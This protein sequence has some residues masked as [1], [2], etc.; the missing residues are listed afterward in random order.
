[1][2]SRSPFGADR[3]SAVPALIVSL[4]AILMGSS[5]AAASCR[6][7]PLMKFQLLAEHGVP[8]EVA[9]SSMFPGLPIGAKIF[10]KQLVDGAPAAG[11]VVAFCPHED[12][13]TLYVKRVIGLPGDRVQMTDDQLYINR[14]PVNRVADGTAKS[15]MGDVLTCYK[16]TLAAR[17][18]RACTAAEPNIYADTPESLVPPGRVFV[19]GDNRDNS[20][21]SRDPDLGLV[22]IED[23]VGVSVP[24]V[25]NLIGTPAAK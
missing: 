11:D 17:T 14:K 21:D 1:M 16:E 18:Y 3:L 4:I 10:A 13:P 9:S 22:K 8:L 5:P 15:D 12:D 23:V 7:S 24:S 6:L 25:M 20:V 19:L 2:R